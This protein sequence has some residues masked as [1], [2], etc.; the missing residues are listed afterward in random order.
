MPAGRQMPATPAAPPAPQTPAAADDD[1]GW[2][3]C[4]WDP[5]LEMRRS[6]PRKGQPRSLPWWK[7]EKMAA[8]GEVVPIIVGGRIIG[9][10]TP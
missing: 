1:D 2:V 10:R 7:L 8:R 3:P 4:P 6:R 9:Y 5:T